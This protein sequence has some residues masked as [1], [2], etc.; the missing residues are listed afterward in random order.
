MRPAPDDST[1]SAVRSW[2]S[3]TYNMLAVIHD[4][5]LEACAMSGV[6]ELHASLL[7]ST[8]DSSRPPNR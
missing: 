2:S 4:R 3:A 1:R 7:A 5:P 8:G 6:G